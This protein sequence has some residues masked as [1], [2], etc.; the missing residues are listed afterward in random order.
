[1][2]KIGKYRMIPAGTKVWSIALQENVTFDKDIPVKITNTVI[3]NKTYVYGTLQLLLFEY[4]IPSV[5]D[6]ANGDIGFSLKDT[7]KWEVPKPQI[8]NI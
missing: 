3:G 2:S 4:M 5:M 8:F 6:K 1:M 7:T